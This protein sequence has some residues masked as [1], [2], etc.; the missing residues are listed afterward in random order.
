MKAKKTNRKK[1]YIIETKVSIENV[2][3]T[4][5]MNC[6]HS[7]D[8][9]LIRFNKLSRIGHECHVD[10]NIV[11]KPRMLRKSFNSRQMS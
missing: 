2:A 9:H 6:E 8:H 4:P 11:I 1:G 7:L 5:K 10:S 3:C